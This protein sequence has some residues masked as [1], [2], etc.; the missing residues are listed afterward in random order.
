MKTG[1]PV[2]LI[3]DDDPTNIDILVDTLN[4]TYDIIIAKTGIQAID[5]VEARL[6]DL[7]LLDIMMPEMD[8]YELCRRLKADEKTRNIPVI[9]VT[10]MSDADDEFRGLEL[11][12]IDYLVKPVKPPLVRA[13][14]ENQLKLR[15]AMLEL[16]RLNRLALDANPNTG[17]PGNNSITRAISAAIDNQEAVCVV[18]ADL[19]H[20]KAYN[21]TYGFARGDA[22]I[23]FTAATIRSG[24]DSFGQ[25]AAFIGHIGGDDFIF[26]IPSDICRTACE[27]II[28]QF[29]GGVTAFYEPEHIRTKGTFS[30]N[31]VGKKIR[32]PLLSISLAAVDLANRP[33]SQ[34]LQV[35]DACA[36]AKHV[37]KGISGSAFFM[38]RRKQ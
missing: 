1:Q 21:D 34:Y 31:R 6:P 18:Y 27:E 35:T 7:I 13:R 5:R 9:F 17:L 26:I 15:Y 19:D 16:E 22:V 38:E 36:E 11:G 33:F 4:S 25:A 37:A 2:V 20:F 14:V 12:A 3:V 24:L 32:Y 23:R 29:N 8:G 10:A 30:V 28:D